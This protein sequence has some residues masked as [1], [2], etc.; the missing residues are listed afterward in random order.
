MNYFLL[1]NPCE[2]CTL[3]AVS[4][5]VASAAAWHLSP[6]FA[7]RPLPPHAGDLP[8]YG[9][10]LWRV[11]AAF[12]EAIG[13]VPAEFVGRGLVMQ[14]RRRDAQRRLYREF[15]KASW[16]EIAE[17]LESVLVGTRSRAD[18]RTLDEL[19]QRMDSAEWFDFLATREDELQDV[20]NSVSEHARQAA[21]ELR[22][23]F[24]AGGGA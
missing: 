7:A 20:D 24:D 6:G 1:D 11:P 4:A 5:E 19:R 18:R 12:Y 21:R 14:K 8:D 16:E 22:R 10:A 23:R 9:V 13:F 2:D 15:L 3:A 17:A